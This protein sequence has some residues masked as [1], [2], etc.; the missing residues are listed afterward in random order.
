MSDASL[1]SG[2]FVGLFSGVFVAP[3]SSGDSVGGVAFVGW[4]GLA[5]GF[6]LCGFAG[7]GAGAA[8][9][10]ELGLAVEPAGV[11]DLAHK[12]GC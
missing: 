10:G 8:P 4:A 1:S 11:A 5:S 2:G 7:G 6:A 3:R 12:G 9:A